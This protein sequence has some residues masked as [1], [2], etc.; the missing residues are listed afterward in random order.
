MIII[1]SSGLSNQTEPKDRTNFRISLQ[2]YFYRAFAILSNYDCDFMEDKKTLIASVSG[3]C[4]VALFMSFYETPR[5]TQF[6]GNL[7]FYFTAGFNINRRVSVKCKLN[8]KKYIL[9]F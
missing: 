5:K 4:L 8:K 3:Y 1:I 6:V 9:V 7:L 2:F